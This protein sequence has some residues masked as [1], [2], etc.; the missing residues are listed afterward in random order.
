LRCPSEPAKSNGAV[1]HVIVLILITESQA[2]FNYSR[3]KAEEFRAMTIKEGI[4]ANMQEF[5]E[6]Q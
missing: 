1:S 2:P 4:S 6:K 5:L 3:I